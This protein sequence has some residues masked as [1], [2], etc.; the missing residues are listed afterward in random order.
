MGPVAIKKL[1]EN[2]LAEDKLKD[3]QSELNILSTIKPHPN[4]I[5]YLGYCESENEIL[6]VT[7]QTCIIFTI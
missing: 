3:L 7:V 6:I 1:K 2:L 5:Q 4:I